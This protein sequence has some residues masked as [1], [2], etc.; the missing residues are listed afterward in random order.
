LLRPLAAN[1]CCSLLGTEGMNELFELIEKRGG[2][3]QSFWIRLEDLED[4]DE[5]RMAKQICLSAPST[6]DS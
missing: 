6:A 1:L 2:R 4:K 3:P 5:M